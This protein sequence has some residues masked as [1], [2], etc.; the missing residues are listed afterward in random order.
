VNGINVMNHVRTSLSIHILSYESLLK[1]REIVIAPNPFKDKFILAFK[2]EVQADCELQIY[3]YYGKLVFNNI[4]ISRE[5]FNHIEIDLSDKPGGFYTVKLISGK[6]I[7]HKKIIK[8][9]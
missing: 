7:L 5:G 9:G 1:D 6:K 4:F 3:D 2:E 8:S